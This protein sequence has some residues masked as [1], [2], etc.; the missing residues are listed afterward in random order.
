M[1]RTRRRESPIAPNATNTTSRAPSFQM[2]RTRRHELASVQLQRTRIREIAAPRPGAVLCLTLAARSPDAG[3]NQH[4]GSEPDAVRRHT[5]RTTR[6]RY[7]SSGCGARS[8]RECGPSRGRPTCR[9]SPAPARP[10]P[11]CGPASAP[12]ASTRSRAPHAAVR[13]AHD[14]AGV[15]GRMAPEHLQGDGLAA[16]RPRRARRARRQALYVARPARHLGA[17]HAPRPRAARRRSSSTSR[18]ARRS[19]VPTVRPTGSARHRAALVE[20]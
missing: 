3:S 10:V 11:P 19:S 1:Q 4:H 14:A 5:R 15:G 9:C 12:R 17:Q 18:A 20:E 8:R 7:P 2:Q 6:V 13:R 16:P